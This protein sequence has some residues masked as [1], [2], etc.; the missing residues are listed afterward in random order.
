MRLDGRRFLTAEDGNAIATYPV[1]RVGVSGAKVA[2]KVGSI[3]AAT[4]H[5]RDDTG[6][7]FAR[8]LTGEEFAALRMNGGFDV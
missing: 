6:P 8:S 7:R 3:D 1:C 2:G 4:R 5:H